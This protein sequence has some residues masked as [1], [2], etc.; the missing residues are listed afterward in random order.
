MNRRHPTAEE[1]LPYSTYVKFWFVFFF[2]FW[3]CSQGISL[4]AAFSI[5]SSSRYFVFRLPST[6]LKWKYQIFTTL[7]ISCWGSAV[8]VTK[9][10]RKLSKMWLAPQEFSFRYN[11][12][13][14]FVNQREHS[15]ICVVSPFSLEQS[16]PRVREMVTNSSYFGFRES[17]RNRF[18]YQGSQ[19]NHHLRA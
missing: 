17:R 1:T 5:L 18:H 3:Q 2:F 14:F 10:Q 7:F 11:V 8:H 6:Y 13:G 4:P 12:L 19:I 15:L 16:L 9:T